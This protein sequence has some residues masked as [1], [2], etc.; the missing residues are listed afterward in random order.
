LIIT[1]TIVI[2]LSLLAAGIGCTDIGALNTALGAMLD[3]C[4]QIH[5]RTGI[6]ACKGSIC[7]QAGRNT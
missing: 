3:I 1:M 6:T 2:T 4:I 7:I 5:A